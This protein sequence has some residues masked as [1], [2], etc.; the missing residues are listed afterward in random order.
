LKPRDLIAVGAVVLIGGF[1]AAD[2]IRGR[3]G[4]SRIPPVTSVGEQTTPTRLSGPRPQQEAP[5][6]WP[7]G[8]LRGALIFTDATDCRVRVVGL[9]GGVERPLAR[10]A[11]ACS[12]WTPAAGPRFAYGLGP[13]SGDG[14]VPFRIADLARPNRELGGYRALFGVVIWSADGQR[15]AWCG[16]RRTGFDL[17]V[18]G[19]AR[20]L[21][22]CPVAYT[23]DNRIAYTIGNRLIVDG[24]TVVRANGG[25]TFVHYGMDGS[26]AIV[27]DGKRLVRYDP[28]GR[29]DASV[30]IPD[31][32]TPILSPTNCGA[33]FNPFGGLGRIR[34]VELPCYRGRRVDG[35]LGRDASWS[36]DGTWIAVAEQRQIAFYRTTAFAE[37]IRWPAAA[38]QLVWHER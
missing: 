34:F 21:P 35:L 32:R 16:R 1:A 24:R 18:G 17:E 27:E 26:L 13:T 36:P 25:I 22:H 2:A 37:P 11:G 15:V 12:L 29:L 5:R 31:G 4:E 20:R 6:G 7:L 10:F 28:A 38:A 23:P 30:P 8:T 9:G 3:V 33:L 14:F 19:P